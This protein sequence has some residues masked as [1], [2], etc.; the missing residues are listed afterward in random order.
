MACVD[1]AVTVF[2]S[3]YLRGFSGAAGWLP[4]FPFATTSHLITEEDTAS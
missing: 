3:L 2:A 1:F 4:A